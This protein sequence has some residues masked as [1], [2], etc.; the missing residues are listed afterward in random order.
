MRDLG[1]PPRLPRLPAGPV[2][3]AP[4]RRP[5]PAAAR[6]PGAPRTSRSRKFSDTD[7]DAY[8]PLGRLAGRPRPAA[9][10]AA[11]A[12]S[13]PSWARGARRPARQAALLR[14]LRGR[15]RA[16]APSTSPGCSPPA[17]PT[18]S[19]TASSPTRCAACSSVCGVIGTWAG[20]RSPGTAYVMAHHH[21]GDIGD[22]QHRRLGLPARRHG[23]RHP[24]AGRRGPLVR[25][26]HPHRRGG[27][28]HQYAR[29]RGHRG[30]ARRRRRVRGADRHHHGAPGDLVPAS[31]STAATC[32]PDFVAD[33]E[34]WQ[35]AQRHGE[36][37]PRR[38]PAAGRSPPTPGSTR[39]STAARSCSPSRSTTS[40]APSRRRSA[41]GRRRCRSPTSASPA[42]STRPLAPAGQARR[43]DVHP[44]GAAHLGRRPARGRARRVRRPAGRRAWSA[45]APGFTDSVLDRQVIG[46]YEMEHEYGLIGGNIFHGEL[47]VGQMF[48]GRPAAGLRRPAYPDP[49]ALPGRLRHPR[50]R[51]GHRHPRTQRRPPGAGRPQGRQRPCAAR[52][53]SRG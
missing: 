8:R 48:H 12:R 14:R 40:R 35:V 42:C 33:I 6:R 30:H 45:V 11:R 10:P 44:V 22:G 15:R 36:G 1:W 50:R 39:R 25:R 37:Q 16:R 41:A 21:V 26:R 34:R 5:L 24:G 3:R 28:P 53:G 4:P 19:R 38:R 52:A 31:W 43:V 27:R 2:L 51:R 49:R 17:S 46:P 29:R 32:P 47:T 13:R 20:P 23:R 18:W 7:A 9:R